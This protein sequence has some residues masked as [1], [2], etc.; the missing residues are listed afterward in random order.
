MPSNNG[1]QQLNSKLTVH[2]KGFKCPRCGACSFE[3][4]L[5][6]KCPRSNSTPNSA[7]P[8][9]DSNNLTTDEKELLQ[10]QLHSEA[11]LM[12]KEFSNL[13]LEMRRSFNERNIDPRD[14]ATT[15]LTI[16]P[17]E[18][19]TRSLSDSASNIMQKMDC[20]SYHYR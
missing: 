14:I 13:V 19:L 6:G 12:I 18:P 10:A 5:G 20:I 16:A 2:Q 7:F 4:Y 3:Q 9:L 8:Y 1:E 11:K 17:Q 15:I